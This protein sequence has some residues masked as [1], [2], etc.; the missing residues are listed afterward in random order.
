MTTPTTVSPERNAHSERLR[1]QRQRVSHIESLVRTV[2]N[3][4]EDIDDNA[5]LHANSALELAADLLNDVN[6][7]NDELRVAIN[8]AEVQS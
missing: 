3:T 8:E 5:S 7:V 1:A 2:L 4:H 6:D